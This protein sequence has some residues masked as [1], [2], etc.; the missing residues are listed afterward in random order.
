MIKMGHVRPSRTK[1][2]N[3]EDE[4]KLSEIKAARSRE[5]LRRSRKGS[6]IRRKLEQERKHVRNP[7]ESLLHTSTS[8]EL[9]LS[10]FLLSIFF[11]VSDLILHCIQPYLN[12]KIHSRQ[13]KSDYIVVF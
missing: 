1:A 4:F 11:V 7:R 3:Q 9:A 2:Q 12:N 5:K 10:P 6:A 13:P 8:F